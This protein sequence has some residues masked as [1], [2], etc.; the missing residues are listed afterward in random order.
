MLQIGDELPIFQGMLDSGEEFNLEDYRGK[1][2]IFYFYP[3]DNTPGCTAEACNIRDNYTELKNR[4]ILIFGVSTDSVTSH[5][6]FK[7]KYNLSFPLIA[8]KDKKISKIF[9]VLKKTG[10]AKRVTFLVDKER[11]IKFVWEKV[12]A[13]THAEQILETISN[14]N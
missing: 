13:K 7:S 1:D 6:K 4:G 3:K 9:G 14:M 11:K 8:D 10:T 12:T 2:L 5:Q